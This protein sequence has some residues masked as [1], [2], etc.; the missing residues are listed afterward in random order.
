MKKQQRENTYFIYVLARDYGFAP[1]PFHGFCTLACCKPDIREHAQVGDWVIG[2]TSKKGSGCRYLLYALQVEEISNFTK[3]W[4]DSRF[5]CKKPYIEGS[6]KY[7]YGDNIY[8]KDSKGNWIQ[9]NSH[10]CDKSKT[11]IN[12][13]NRDRDTKSEKVL[14]SRKFYYFGDKYMEAHRELK[15]P[16]FNIFDSLSQKHQKL[17]NRN[18]IKNKKLNLV[19][20][21]ISILEKQTKYKKGVCHGD[22]L[23][24]SQHKKFQTYG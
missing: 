8:H 4:K 18:D 15:L 24:W 19:N 10:H 1:N 22:P 17:P 6:L 14:I 2:L 21:V 16:N 7:A 20:K 13:E 9:E 5:A 12:K 23:K 11:K 3:Y